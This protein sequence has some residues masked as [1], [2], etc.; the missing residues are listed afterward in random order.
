M[1]RIGHL[2]ISEP[3]CGF[4]AVLEA[5]IVSRTW[6]CRREKRTYA[7]RFWVRIK[8]PKGFDSTYIEFFETIQCSSYE[9]ANDVL[10]EIEKNLSSRLNE[11]DDEMPPIVPV[12]E[13]FPA[14]QCS[15]P[16]EAC[17]PKEVVCEC[18]GPDNLECGGHCDGPC[19]GPCAEKAVQTNSS[20]SELP[21]LSQE[22][23]DQQACCFSAM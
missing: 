23:P 9:E 4:K 1:V 10:D 6:F 14:P 3:I 17:V 20:A 5:T 22:V 16:R 7:V 2:V 11:S 15:K 8:A 19:G 12:S 21:E 13:A 18:G